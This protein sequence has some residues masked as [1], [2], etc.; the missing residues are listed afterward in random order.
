M[1]VLFLEYMNNNIPIIK[2][3]PET[4]LEALYMRWFFLCIVYHGVFDG[5]AY[6]IDLADR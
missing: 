3:D 2:Q 1:P 6:G 4:I 5:I